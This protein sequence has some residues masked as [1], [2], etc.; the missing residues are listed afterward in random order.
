MLSSLPLV[1]GS[2][3]VPEIITFFMDVT[4]SVQK[5]LHTLYIGHDEPSYKIKS[6][7]SKGYTACVQI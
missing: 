7:T 3:P 5:K 1:T 6:K 4:I 2:I